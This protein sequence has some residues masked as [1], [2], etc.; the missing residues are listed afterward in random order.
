MVL[1]Q[2][3]TRVYKDSLTLTYPDIWLVLHIWY[4]WVQ[5]MRVSHMFKECCFS[6]RSLLG[7][8]KRILTLTSAWP[9]GVWF[10]GWPLFFLIGDKGVELKREIFTQ[11]IFDQPWNQ[12]P[13]VMHMSSQSYFTFGLL[14]PVSKI[15]NSN[16]CD[17]HMRPILTL[18]CIIFSMLQLQSYFTTFILH[19]HAGMNLQC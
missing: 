11:N 18:I 2:T 7:Q 8:G 13:K 6:K 3:I 14:N 19:D 4:P 12:L 9:C 15:A 5:R 1:T 17:P 16:V 10:Q